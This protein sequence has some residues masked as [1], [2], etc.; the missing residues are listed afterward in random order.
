MNEF[1]VNRVMAYKDNEGELH[2]LKRDAGETAVKIP[3]R[4]APN[5]TLFTNEEDA[6]KFMETRAKI[7]KAKR[8]LERHK[9]ELQ[10]LQKSDD[11]ANELIEFAHYYKP[12]FE[13]AD[14]ARK[15]LS[16]PDVEKYL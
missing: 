3:V 16:K 2:S 6:S 5:G 11:I 14:K 8:T 1:N 9:K 4:R 12:L 15:I 13:A 10:I 7:L